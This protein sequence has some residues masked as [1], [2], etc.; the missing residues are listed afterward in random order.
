MMTSLLIFWSITILLFMPLM[1]TPLGL[2]L[3]IL[4]L[5]LMI[6]SNMMFTMSSWFS[7][8]LFLIYIGG[9]LVMFAYF[10][11]I[12]PNKKINLMS[13]LFIPILFMTMLLMM[14]AKLSWSTQL[15]EF[16]NQHQ[17]SFPALFFSNSAMFLIIMMLTLLL[18]L[19]SVVKI[20]N[21]TQGP[22]RP[23]M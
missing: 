2:G 4:L 14:S 21:R 15:M 7:F 6:A 22:L 3:W 5:A 11:A 12:D 9:L 17:Y 18:I 10:S 19:I 1:T 13:P 8:I 20:T 16:S 23:F